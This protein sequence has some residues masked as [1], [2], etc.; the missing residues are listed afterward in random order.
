M[1]LVIMISFNIFLEP[2]ANKI[3]N[4]KNMLLARINDIDIMVNH[5]V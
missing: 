5:W 1:A 3:Y 4:G 2:D